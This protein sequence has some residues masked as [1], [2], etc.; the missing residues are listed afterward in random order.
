MAGGCCHR[1]GGG[2]ERSKD[3]DALFFSSSSSQPSTTAM[4]AEM[5]R[6]DRKKADAAM[7][8]VVQLSCWDP[9]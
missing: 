8:S 9:G 3:Q 5:A 2:L 4:R 6:W 1:C 7:E